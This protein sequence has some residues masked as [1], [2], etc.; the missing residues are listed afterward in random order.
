MSNNRAS[1]LKERNPDQNAIVDRKRQPRPEPREHKLE[2]HSRLKR[3]EAEARWK[4]VKEIIVVVSVAFISVG[5]FTILSVVL[6]SGAYPSTD[7]LI[8]ISFI[9]Q[10]LTNLFL[11]MAGKVPKFKK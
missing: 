3:E 10:L 6:L 2:M 4:L 11:Y 9:T 8:L 5:S 7:K 1:A